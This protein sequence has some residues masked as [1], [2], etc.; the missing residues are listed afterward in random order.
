VDFGAV[1][2]WK[3]AMHERA[4]AAFSAGRARAL[5][6]PFEAFRR[7]HAAWLD[8]FAL[9][10]TLKDRHGGWPWPEWDAAL[11]TRDPRALDAARRAGAGA[12]DAQRFRHF[13]FFR[14]WAALR[15]HARAR[16][17]RI[18]GDLPIFV[19]HDSA[20]VWANPGLF[21]LDARGRCTVVAGVPPDY[22]SATG[23]LWGNPLYR[24]DVLEGDGYAWWIERV[25]AT[26]EMVDVVRLDH[27]RGFDA[28]W[29]IPGDAPT[30]VAGR[31]VPGPGAAFF[32]ALRA[33]I[34][35]L[36]LI[37][38]DLGVVTPSMI[39]LRDRFGLPGMKVLQFAFGG[40]PSH[41]FL[42][43]RFGRECVVYTGTHDNDTTRG[44][45]ATAPEKERDFARRYLGRDG[46]DIAWDLIRAAFAS[47]ADTAVVPL[48]DVLDLGGEARMNL[49]GR[50]GGNWTW[51]FGWDQ[52][53]GF[54]RGRL[55]D[56]VTLYSRRPGDGADEAAA[57][58][59][60]GAPATA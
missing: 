9:F 49:P 26:L 20:D 56:L 24:W 59:A 55:R 4:W 58:A 44:W 23:Q 48:Q 43:H 15:R 60:E 31:W 45:Y 30:A 13:L 53:T 5:R 41:P 33:A 27:F 47:V 36:P 50:L 17:V 14:Q 18:V 34:G 19:A 7:T 51:R 40:D 16:G 3:H 57:R 6:E 1:I 25:R 37:A 42:P 28:Y 10:M 22:F 8:D 35:S 38:E 52:L 32:E 21:H 39:A 29:E 11:A 12:M 46:H 54:H 2:A